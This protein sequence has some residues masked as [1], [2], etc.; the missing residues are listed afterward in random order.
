MRQAPDLPGAKPA[1]STLKSR[2]AKINEITQTA[3]DAK[4]I[5]GLAIGIVKNREIAYAAGFGVRSLGQSDKLATSRMGRARL[6][7]PPRCIRIAGNTPRA[8]PCKPMCS[9]CVNLPS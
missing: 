3:I 5:A 8:A 2:L 7:R 9:I 4:R 6:R 1:L